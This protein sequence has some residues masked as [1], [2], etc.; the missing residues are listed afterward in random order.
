[1]NESPKR[2]L[3]SFDQA[4]L[5]MLQQDNKTSQRA[6]AEAIGLSTPAVQRRIAQL[7][8]SGVIVSNTA[9]IAP[10]SV[11][12]QITAIVESRLCDDRAVVMNRAK[13]YFAGVSEVQQC[14]FVSGGVSFIIVMLARDIAHFDQLV[15][16]H[17]AGNEDIHT[18]RTLIVLD[19]V[20]VGLT[21]P[22]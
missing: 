15:Q 2:A 10:E 13:R 12:Q 22:V 3:D 20:K 5:R 18:Y 21:V 19:K 4:I 17:F 8:D 14:Y 1:M 11:G 7:E 16:Q 6:I 9:V